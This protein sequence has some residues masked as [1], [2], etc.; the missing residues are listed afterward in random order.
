MAETIV[1]GKT[2]YWWVVLDMSDDLCGTT[3]NRSC[4][5]NRKIMAEYN[6]VPTVHF[7]TAA[8]AF[9]DFVAKKPTF[10][11]GQ[12]LKLG[13]Q[14]Y[15]SGSA[16]VL[17]TFPH[18]GNKVILTKDQ[19]VAVLLRKTIIDKSKLPEALNTVATLTEI[20]RLRAENAAL[21]ASVEATKPAPSFFL[22]RIDS[23][24]RTREVANAF[25]AFYGYFIVN[26]S[27]FV[28]GV[29]PATNCGF[30]RGNKILKDTKGV[31]CSALT[32]NNVKNRK[33]FAHLLT[34]ARML[35]LTKRVKQTVMPTDVFEA[36]HK[37]LE[38]FVDYVLLEHVETD[39]WETSYDIGKAVPGYGVTFYFRSNLPLLQFLNSETC[40]KELNEMTIPWVDRLDREQA[41][42]MLQGMMICSSEKDATIEVMSPHLARCVKKL[43][44][45]SGHL[46]KIE[47]I[48]E[49][50]WTI[51]LISDT[52]ATA[53]A[54][55]IRDPC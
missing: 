7:P 38:R 2:V 44:E 26:C 54:S 51:H 9:D 23:L 33:Q 21:R 17:H 5:W 35:G 8:E 27:Q 41:W 19:H 15:E 11:E 12:V 40:G 50:L 29:A 6:C 43:C 39:W 3:V 1:P 37:K 55:S 14:Q 13:T 18:C 52:T 20:E 31:D 46:C 30:S 47:E 42:H 22:P 34:N 10:V 36:P 48:G 25:A 16:Y 28:R 32:F 24:E 45:I 4:S 49:L 53:T